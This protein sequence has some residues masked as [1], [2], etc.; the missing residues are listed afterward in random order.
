MTKLLRFAWPLSALALMLSAG[1]APSAPSAEEVAAVRELVGSWSDAKA[2]DAALDKL[3]RLGEKGAF[4]AFEAI[5][6]DPKSADEIANVLDALR[7]MKGDRGR[8]VTPAVR[9][10]AHSQLKVRVGAAELLGQIGS[11]KE[12]S[13][14]VALL[15]DADEAAVSAAARTLAA[16]GGPRELVAMDAW[17]LGVSHKDNRALRDRVT[18]FRDDLKAR[19]DKA[20]KDKKK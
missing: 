18:G 14:L 9:A 1:V 8:F 19:L 15:S 10:L 3:H 7:Q 16:V 17:L 6:A 2:R 12:A 11:P 13:P 4:P 5:L 20:A